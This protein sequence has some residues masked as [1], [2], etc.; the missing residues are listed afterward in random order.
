MCATGEQALDCVRPVKSI[1]VPATGSTKLGAETM[2]AI[3][4]EV[5][6]KLTHLWGDEA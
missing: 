4:G 6:T 5:G 2:Q 3:R 1:P